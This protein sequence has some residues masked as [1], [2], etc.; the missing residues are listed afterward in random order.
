[1]SL[2]RRISLFVACSTIAGCGG[3]TTAAVSSTPVLAANVVA[4]SSLEFTPPT[5]TL[6]PG[7]TVTF[8]FQSVAHNVFF[9]ND[10]EGAP[11]NITA[12]TANKSVTLTFNTPGRFVY[13]CH[14][15]PGMSGVVIVQ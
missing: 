4:A 7:G 13:N 12:P 2:I 9:D 6:L 14:I 1:M 11:Q 10:D 3:E 15:H 5:V 8:Q